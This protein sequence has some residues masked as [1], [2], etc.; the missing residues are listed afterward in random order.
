MT[1]S[2]Q[3]PSGPRTH[4]A[5][6][7]TVPVPFAADRSNGSSTDG[8]GGTEGSHGQQAA[9]EAGAFP[10][11]NPNRPGVIGPRP[12]LVPQGENERLF[13]QRRAE[14]HFDVVETFVDGCDPRHPSTGEPG[15]W[16]AIPGL[17]PGDPD[18][19]S[20]TAGLPTRGDPEFDQAEHAHAEPGWTVAS[21][22]QQLCP[23]DPKSP[24][25]GGR[26]R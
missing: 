5:L 8:P 20:R 6:I 15:G 24:S 13:G 7:P 21:I 9:G 12:P 3:L 19:P 4:L 2:P 11:Q 22:E 23:S 10:G 18:P 26:P 25:P 14:G 16:F 17:A 1:V